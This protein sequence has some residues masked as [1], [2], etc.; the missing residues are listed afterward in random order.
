MYGAEFLIVKMFLNSKFQTISRVIQHLTLSVIPL[1]SVIIS[2]LSVISLLYVKPLELILR[3]V[4]TC[5]SIKLMMQYR[6]QNTIFSY[7]DKYDCCLKYS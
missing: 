4:Y 7:I 2:L 6:E 5:W 3:Q 1:L